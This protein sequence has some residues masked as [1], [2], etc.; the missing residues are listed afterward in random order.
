M[1][2]FLPYPNF[3]R[4]A[5]VLDNKR[6]GKQRVECLQILKV[7]DGQTTAWR[8][9][10][11]VRMWRGHE[12]YLVNYGRAICKEWTRRGFNDTCYQKITKFY[13]K[14]PNGDAPPPWF[15]DARF[16]RSHRSN[17]K[18]KDPDHYSLFGTRTDLPYVWPV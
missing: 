7:L 12:F 5:K 8:N 14:F 10:P 3:V 13:K 17:L 4:S 9:H 18:R 16:H 1:Q 15:G 11:A 6:L 2:T